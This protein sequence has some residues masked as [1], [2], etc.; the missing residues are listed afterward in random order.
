[1]SYVNMN[2]RNE[3]M[4]MNLTPLEI[5]D[6]VTVSIFSLAFSGTGIY[7]PIKIILYLLILDI[8]GGSL[9]FKWILSEI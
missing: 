4:T 8:Q 1:M 9:S 5:T 2:H 6:L 7:Q 3:Y